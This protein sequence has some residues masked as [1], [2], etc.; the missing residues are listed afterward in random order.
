MPKKVFDQTELQSRLNEFVNDLT[1]TYTSDEEI[2]KYSKFCASVYALKSVTDAYYT[3]D[4]DGKLPNVDM[5]QKL[6]IM[7]LYKQAIDNAVPL[8]DMEDSGPLGTQMNTII[9]EMLPLLQNDY[10]TLDMASSDTLISLPELISRGR[11]QVVDLGNQEKS[12]SKGASSERQ[13]IIVQSENGS[14]DGYFT[15]E[16]TVD[17]NRMVNLFLDDIEKKHDPAFKAFTDKIRKMPLADIFEKEEVELEVSLFSGISKK[18]SKEQKIEKISEKLDEV[19]WNNL[20]IWDDET[21]AASNRDDYLKFAVDFF[22]GFKK[23]NSYYNRNYGKDDLLKVETGAN[24]D[25]RNVAMYRMAGL[26]GKPNLVAEARPMTVI[27]NGVP[28]TGTFMATAYGV[29][30][31]RVKPGDPFLDYTSKNFDNPAVFDDIAAMQALDYICGNT[32]RHV[33]NIIFRFEPKDAKDAKLVGISLIDND[34]S[35]GNASESTENFN[36][37][38][39][40]GMGVLGEDFYNSMCAMTREQME[41]K[42]SDCK[43]S[44]DELD[45]AWERKEA[46]QKKIEED[47]EYFK[48]KEPGYTEKGRIRLVKKEEW[49]S[50]SIDNLARTHKTGKFA[51]IIESVNTAKSVAKHGNENKGEIIEYKDIKEELGLIE[52]GPKAANPKPEQVPVGHVIGNG[53]VQNNGNELQDDTV[54][55][56]IPNLSKIPIS[57]NNLSKRYRISYEDDGQTK[58]VFFTEAQ[59]CGYRSAY[60]KI[61]LEAEEK[62]P[63]YTEVLANIRDYYST[64]D[65]LENYVPGRFDKH[66]WKEMGFSGRKIEELS[67]DNKFLGILKDVTTKLDDLQSRNTVLIPNGLDFREGKRLEMRNVAM[68]D[69][70]DILDVPD[71]IAR[72]KPVQVMSGGRIIDGVAMDFADGVDISNIPYNHPMAQ[73]PLD[74]INDV[75][76]TEEGLKSLSD[77][78]ITDF[79]CLNIDRHEQNLVYKF[80]GLGTDN[81]KFTGVIGIDN[82]ASFGAI[83]PDPGEQVDKLCSLNSMQVISEKMAAKVQD[84]ETLVKLEEKL[85]SRGLS[86]TEINAAKKRVEMVKSAI[87]DGRLK[88]VKNGEW[89]KGDYTLDKLSADTKS[90][91]H[92][93]NYRAFNDLASKGTAYRERNNGVV[94]PYEKKKPSFA[95]SLKVDEFGTVARDNKELA[96]LEKKATK[97]FLDGVRQAATSAPQDDSLSE[98]DMVNRIKEQATIMY[99]SLDS[100][101]PTFSFTS[102]TYKNVEKAA[103]ELKNLSTRLSKKLKNPGDE[104]SVRDSAK[105]IEAMN[106]LKDATAAYRA[107]KDKEAADGYT[108]G[109][110]VP[111]R[112]DACKNSA[113]NT[114]DLIRNYNATIIKQ[115]AAKDPMFV[116]HERL[117][118]SQADLSGLTGKSLR[119]AVAEVIYYKGLNRMDSEA[120]KT[121]S[122]KNALNPSVM[123]AGR[124]IILNSP[125]FK[126][127]AEMK[128]DELR[129]IAAS[130]D[131][132]KLMKGYIRET[133]RNMQKEKKNNLKVNNANNLQNKKEEIKLNK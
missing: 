56:V 94:K 129:S 37:V 59:D 61:F 31:N 81:P 75:Y 20:E 128:D 45:K 4:K 11:T 38:K 1:D 93:I 97:E 19:L 52:P 96:D 12:V 64:D 122:L 48:D 117:K 9:K 46:L 126:K 83:V 27:Q 57:G 121:D 28:V 13:H 120:R 68:S 110:H 8:L 114:S 14:E 72:S 66:N 84:P 102:R 2:E 109:V 17:F 5:T 49:T 54:K 112:L 132:E 108:P 127:Y 69:V 133:A 73:I 95:K 55:I 34:M 76:N 119:D 36:F 35:F 58:E 85:K 18:L 40:R 60:N 92:R 21:E 98:K 105:L 22:E 7:N 130:R 24:I 6:Q 79:I 25:R 103:K 100:A 70:G 116:L 74:K 26:L 106:K 42:L 77:L 88:I 43:L 113:G 131:G 125:A 78:Q 91:Y 104:L 99:D 89:A 15:A 30:V 65:N 86:E 44:K 115:Q 41:F 50:Y 107:K 71:T 123:K 67:K 111:S 87:D 3:P 51:K 62:N 90:F 23:L 80:E 39:L 16:T 33:G 32:D 63:E 118:R 10:E 101:D 124:N 82:D 53:V 29:D 47:I